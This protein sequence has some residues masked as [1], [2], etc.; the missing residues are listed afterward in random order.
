MVWLLPTC[1]V[2]GAGGEFIDGCVYK[3]YRIFTN[4]NLPVP[5]KEEPGVWER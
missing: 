2:G 1:R 4:S 5:R 3:V